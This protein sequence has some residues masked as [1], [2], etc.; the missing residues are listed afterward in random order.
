MLRRF[1][2]TSA[3]RVSVLA[4]LAASLTF[5]AVR[6]RADDG[7]LPQCFTDCQEGYQGDLGECAAG[8]S[9]CLDWCASTGASHNVCVAQC[10]LER[11]ECTAEA[12]ADWGDCMDGCE[13][14]EF[15][16]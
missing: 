7:D 10:S 13:T 5:L 3:A 2:S 9:N 12:H 4:L 1:F 15:G 6:A 14:G 16:D 8:Y 11:N